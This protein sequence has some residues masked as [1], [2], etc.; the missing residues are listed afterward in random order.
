MKTKQRYLMTILFC[1]MFAISPMTASARHRRDPGAPTP[2]QPTDDR[3]GVVTTIDIVLD[4][5]GTFILG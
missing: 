3:I 4:I 2:M 5:L 1:L